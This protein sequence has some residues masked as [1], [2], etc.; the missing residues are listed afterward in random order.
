MAITRSQARAIAQGAGP[1]LT[2]LTALGITGTLGLTV[3][4]TSHMTLNTTSDNRQVRINSRSFVQTSGGSIAFQAKPSQTVNT[5]GDVIGGEISPRCQSGVEAGQIKG[6]H[7][8]TDLKGTAAGTIGTLSVLELEAVADVSGGRTITNDLSL[9][10]CRLFCPASGG[11]SGD[12]VVLN[13]PVPET[14]SVP[15][16]AFAKFGAV[17]GL[18]AIHGGAGAALPADVGWVR[19][20]IGSTFYK[21]PAY[22]DA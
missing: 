1:A 21:L 10:K 12:A 9:I 17:A 6:L 4:A 20:K 14:G 5:T 11:V 18:A 3:P 7:V 13:V 19:I 16:D 15:Y 22:N 8:D 2:T